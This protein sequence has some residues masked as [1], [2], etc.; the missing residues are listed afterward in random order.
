ME[1]INDLK[2]SI[3]AGM[4]ASEKLRYGMILGH[5]SNIIGKFSQDIQPISLKD[6]TLSLVTNSSVMLQHFNMKK[7]ELIDKINEFLDGNIV[8]D[9][10]ISFNSS[11]EVFKFD[12]NIA[13]QED[14]IPIPEEKNTTPPPANF[15]EF[16]LKKFAEIQKL[17]EEREKYL[18]NNGYKK[19]KTC[20]MLFAG[21]ED[22]CIVCIEQKKI[23]KSALNSYKY[24]ENN[25]EEIEKDEENI[26]IYDEFR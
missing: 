19:C 15:N 23:K 6:K 9:I 18:L 7:V 16:I 5:W 25:K 24:K 4:E 11:F 17:S 10:K 20:G 1:K 3:K 14:K 26:N 22:N 21:E 12:N 8:E 2:V 13:P